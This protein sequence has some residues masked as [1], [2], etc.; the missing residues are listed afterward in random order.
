MNLLWVLIFYMVDVKKFFHPVTNAT[1][2]GL[3]PE[4]SYL[5]RRQDTIP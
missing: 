3:S 2:M 1:T 5:S 4:D